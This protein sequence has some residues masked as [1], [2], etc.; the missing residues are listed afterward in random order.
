MTIKMKL[1]LSKPPKEVTVGVAWPGKR[2]QFEALTTTK[3][4]DIKREIFQKAE[5]PVEVQLLTFNGKIL[6]DE[7]SLAYYK[8]KNDRTLLL[9]RI[10]VEL[11]Q[12][13]IKAHTRKNSVAKPLT[14]ADNHLQDVLSLPNESH[15]HFSVTERPQ[16]NSSRVHQP[17]NNP[18][19]PKSAQ[20]RLNAENVNK[21]LDDWFGAKGT[22]RVDPLDPNN[23]TGQEASSDP[24]NSSSQIDQG[25]PTDSAASEVPAP[26]KANFPVYPQMD[27]MKA[28]MEE[29]PRVQEFVAPAA[30]FLEKEDDEEVIKFTVKH[31]KKEVKLK[32]KANQDLWSVK[33]KLEAN[34]VGK[35]GQMT[36]LDADGEELDEEG[37]LEENDISNGTKLIVKVRE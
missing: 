22:P 26:A 28:L 21:F 29:E 3:I 24:N 32:M 33:L 11:T 15:R 4:K 31:G 9:T 18:Q 5:I 23:A 25:A 37:T 34:K 36:L 27:V 10:G 1:F 13:Q 7:H 2:I 12:T 14:S 35:A 19:T 20:N 17:T 30:E 16:P 6:K 8:V